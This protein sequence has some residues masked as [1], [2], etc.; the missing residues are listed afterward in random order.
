MLPDVP[1]TRPSSSI[2][3]AAASTASGVVVG[4]VIVSAMA[5]HLRVG[6]VGRALAA[7]QGGEAVAI[8]VVWL[9]SVS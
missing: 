9:V 6:E 5:E 7:Q 4:D 1:S 8:S 3:L 2:F